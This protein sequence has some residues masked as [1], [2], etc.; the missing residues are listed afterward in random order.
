[1]YAADFFKSLFHILIF[2]PLAPFAAFIWAAANWNK[3][4]TAAITL[5][6][7][8]TL[9]VSVWVFILIMETTH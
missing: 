8:H 5:L 2:I 3:Q 9:A 7:V 4:R 1:M 6:I